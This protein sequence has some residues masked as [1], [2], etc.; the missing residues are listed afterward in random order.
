MLWW[1]TAYK[2]RLEKKY[3]NDQEMFYI[4]PQNSQKYFHKNIY[5]PST[6]I[7]QIVPKTFYTTEKEASFMMLININPI[8]KS[9]QFHTDSIMKYSWE[10]KLR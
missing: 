4:L 1:D 2:M 6:P 10:S 8:I 9:I 3:L 7:K 5:P